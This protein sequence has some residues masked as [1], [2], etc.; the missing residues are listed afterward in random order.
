ML[1]VLLGYLKRVS[2]FA[3]PRQEESSRRYYGNIK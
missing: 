3:K 2:N 1:L